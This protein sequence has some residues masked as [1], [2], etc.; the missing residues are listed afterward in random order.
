MV[1]PALDLDPNPV[2]EGGDPMAEAT[3]FDPDRVR[4]TLDNGEVVELDGGTLV[5]GTGLAALVSF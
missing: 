5:L 3:Q 2:V 4:L 1:A